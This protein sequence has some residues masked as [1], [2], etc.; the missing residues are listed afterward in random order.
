MN[1]DPRTERAILIIT[2]G[3]RDSLSLEDLARQVGLSKFHFH[4]LFKAE[5]GQTPAEYLNRVRLEYAAHLLIMMPDATML[6]VAL[7]CGFSSAAIF[8]RAFRQRYGKSATAY[9]AANP[10]PCAEGPQRKPLDLR[11]LPTRTLRVLRCSL[12]ENALTDVYR[13]M[14]AGSAAPS[15]ALLGIFVDMPFHSARTNCRHFVALEAETTRSP[16]DSMTLQGGVYAVFP[17]SGD[18]DAASDSILRY[19]AEQIAPSSYAVASTLAFERTVVAAPFDD[20]D[21]RSSA[22]ELFIKLRLKYEPVI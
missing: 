5:T 13:R 9:R 1:T 16:V 7:E 22:R 18:L 11:V 10:L 19:H 21:Y 12:N 15:R 20:F 6:S 8:A 14:C 2:T 3:F 17:L 4:R